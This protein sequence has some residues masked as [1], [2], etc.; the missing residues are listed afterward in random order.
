[1]GLLVG[2][3]RHC[4]RG[5]DQAVQTSFSNRR[6]ISN[7]QVFIFPYALSVIWYSSSLVSCRVYCD[8][9]QPQPNLWPAWPVTAVGAFKFQESFKWTRD[10]ENR[11]LSMHIFSLFWYI[12][13]HNLLYLPCLCLRNIKI[14]LTTHQTRTRWMPT[15]WFADTSARAY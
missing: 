3:P 2:Q 14:S 15:R 12:Y 5:L 11:C 9:D 8:P 1:M 6:S 7:L 10:F 4:L 13:T